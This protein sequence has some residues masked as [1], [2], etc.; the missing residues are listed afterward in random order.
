MGGAQNRAS[1]PATAI[2]GRASRGAIGE[3]CADLLRDDDLAIVAHVVVGAVG[4]AGAARAKAGVRDGEAGEVGVVGRGSR[5]GGRGFERRGEVGYA[6]GQLQGGGGL[7]IQCIVGQLGV[8]LFGGWR[9]AWIARVAWRGRGL[10]ADDGR[11]TVDLAEV[12][13][14]NL[15]RV[16]A[17]CGGGRL[18]AGGAGL[19]V[20]SMFRRLAVSTAS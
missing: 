11:G 3:S 8:G 17:G 2:L 13:E 12:C 1:V 9:H 19:T 6:V 10:C 5:A 18:G 14:R 7:V 20:K 16:R 15:S 4:A